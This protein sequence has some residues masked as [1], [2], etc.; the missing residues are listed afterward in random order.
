MLA[1]SI[2]KSDA[3]HFKKHAFLMAQHHNKEF[4]DLIKHP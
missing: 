3:P 1:K 2:N 4:A